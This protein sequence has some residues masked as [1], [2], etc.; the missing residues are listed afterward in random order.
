MTKK[1]LSFITVL[2]ILIGCGKSEEKKES[3]TT[4][5]ETYETIQLEEANIPL[6]YNFS[7]GD[8]FKYKLTTITTSDESIK[9][10]TVI[11]TKLYQTITYFFDLEVL[12]IDDDKTADFSVNITSITLDANLNGQEVKFDSKAE[13]SNEEKLKFIEYA[14]ISNSPYRARVSSRGEV[15]EVTRLDK[16][17]DKMVQLQ[18]Q[19][20]QLTLEQKSQISKNLSESALRPMTQLLFREL[21]EK[22]VGKDSSW[23]KTY[24]AQMSV[25]AIENNATFTVDDFISIDG[26]KGAKISADLT[27]TWTGE[28]KG[29]EEGVNYSFKDPVIS[30]NGMIIF[31]IEKGLLKKAETITS[32]EM[33]VEVKAKDSTQK[34]QTSVRNEKSTNK[35]I[36]EML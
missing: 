20:Q 16:M 33:E 2:I 25:F 14:T 6:R 36:V 13:N 35:N 21:P 17:I 22:P 18:P 19:A 34:M 1:L 8:K 23:I 32:I 5:V 24:P 10:D 11:N 15:F 4:Q 7:K 27:A 29:V 31:N 9:A 30:G 26:D 28:K 3:G 12:E